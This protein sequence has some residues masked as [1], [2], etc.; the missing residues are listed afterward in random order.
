MPLNKPTSAPA[1]ACQI[2]LGPCEFAASSKRPAAGE[3]PEPRACTIQARAGQPIV[4]PWW[5]RVVH[6]LDGMQ[7]P[8]PRLAL[9]YCH[10]PDE[11]IGFLDE[12]DKSS[13]N[14]VARGQ[15][16]PITADD[17]AAEVLAKGDAGIPFEASIKF[18]EGEILVE[19]LEA[20]Q[21]ATVNG[22]QLEGPALI[23]RRWV[24]RGVAV[25]PYGADMHTATNFAA[26]GGE[27]PVRYLENKPMSQLT[28]QAAPPAEI[29]AENASEASTVETS[30]AQAV[31]DD[32][33]NQP[34]AEDP[35]AA[36][37]EAAGDTA[38]N[39]ETP[40]AEMTEGQRFLADFGDRGGVWYAQGKTYAEAQEA[41]IAELRA[42]R[43]ELAGRL[44]QL[45]RGAETAC[46]FQPAKIPGDKQTPDASEFKGKLPDGLAAYAAALRA[47][48]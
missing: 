43:D 38:A 11:L 6:D 46:Q 17:R 36:N 42:E 39:A 33:G 3:I 24:L 18:D 15:I 12:F 29:P 34:P 32:S 28:S 7:L 30:D 37:S 14:L 10:R 16:I 35:N 9:D 8:K 23:V 4:H 2:S 5:G 19:S 25:C 40:P 47:A 22:Y 20:G 41:Y 13:G 44:A 31:A 26:H 48:R 21:V 27:I 1:S 45:D